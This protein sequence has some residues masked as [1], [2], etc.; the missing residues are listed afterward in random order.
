[1]KCFQN[2]YQ[3]FSIT[4]KNLSEG[5][6]IIK[7]NKHYWKI[8]CKTENRALQLTAVVYHYSG[9]MDGDPGGT[10]AEVEDAELSKEST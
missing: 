9:G 10:N 2:H 4:V 3:K 1:M 8:F 6:L 7:K 5:E